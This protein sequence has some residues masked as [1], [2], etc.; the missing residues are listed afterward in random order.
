MKLGKYVCSKNDVVD[1]L[2]WLIMTS[3]EI[4]LDSKI[5]SL[6]FY[7]SNNYF[8]AAA[9]QY[10]RSNGQQLKVSKI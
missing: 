4:I 9:A 5:E 2:I 8:A 6:F 7:A 10:I 1:L 3:I